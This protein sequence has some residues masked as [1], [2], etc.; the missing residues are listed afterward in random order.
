MPK[1][2]TRSPTALRSL[3]DR[4][5]GR[6]W[7][8]LVVAAPAL[9]WLLVTVAPVA[10]AEGHGATWWVLVVATALAG[11]GTLASYVPVT[12]RRPD[13]GCSPCAAVSAAT[14]VGAVLVL[15]GSAGDP[16][17]PVLALAVALF[18]LVQRLAQPP[19]CP[20]DARTDQDGTLDPGP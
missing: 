7:A 4:W 12:G 10:P 19:V 5:P 8:T 13:L 14:V 11:A 17:A 6:R 9:L 16:S 20:T 2:E 15:R 18:G 1:V 3:A